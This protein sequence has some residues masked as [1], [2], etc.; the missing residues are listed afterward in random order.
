MYRSVALTTLVALFFA[1]VEGKGKDGMVVLHW[2]ESEAMVTPKQTIN[3]VV[4]QKSVCVRP[5]H[6]RFR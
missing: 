3:R 2:P 4:S 5:R 1:S 6:T